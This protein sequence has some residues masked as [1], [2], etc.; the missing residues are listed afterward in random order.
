MKKILLLIIVLAF[1]TS[2]SMAQPPHPGGFGGKGTTKLVSGDFKVLKGQTTFSVKF[3]YD[4]MMVGDMTEADY[5]TKKTNE[6]N[7]VK[8]GS[9]DEWAKKWKED[10][11]TRFEPKFMSILSKFVLKAKM[12][13]TSVT[14]DAKTTYTLLVKTTKTEPGLYTGVSVAEKD[15]YVDITVNLVES[16]NPTK[17]IASLTISKSVGSSVSV[18]QF[19]TGLKLA[20]AYENAGHLLGIYLLSVCK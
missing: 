18:A 16:A 11:V 19:D 12:T 17:V 20:N 5:I 10:R 8:V 7:K 2:L 3:S 9:G 13:C 14:A 4:N 1:C 6:Q 15:T